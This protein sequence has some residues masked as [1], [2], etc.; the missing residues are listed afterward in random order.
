METLL[1]TILLLAL[2]MLA[3]A[4]GVIFGGKALQGSCGGVGASCACD[5]AGRPRDCDIHDDELETP[6]ERAA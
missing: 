4:V 2:L 3:M 6:G 5:L 1:L